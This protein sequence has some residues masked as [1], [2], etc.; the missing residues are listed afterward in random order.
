VRVLLDTHI[1]LW[2]LADD[3]KLSTPARDVI[4]APENSVFYSAAS[5]WEMRIKQAIGKL[6]LPSDFAD[7]LAA[8]A[9]EPLA[10]TVD[11]ANALHDLPLLHRDPFDRLLVAQARRE[12][13]T[14]LTHDQLVGQYD[15]ST[16]M[17]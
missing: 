9:F 8:Q 5:V 13:L 7:V 2:W 4:A 11:H 10:V 12:R 14:I 3:S 15:V 6:V 17:A 1:L 16:R